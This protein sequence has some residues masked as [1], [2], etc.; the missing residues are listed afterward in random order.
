MIAGLELWLPPELSVFWWVV[1]TGLS[2]VTSAMTASF[3]IGGGVALI[4]VLLL[5]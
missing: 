2:F 4:T 3:G 1:L 5:E